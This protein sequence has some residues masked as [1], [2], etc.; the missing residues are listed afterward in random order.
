MY[1]SIERALSNG[2]KFRPL[3]ESIRDTLA[4]FKA[5]RD[6][7]SLRAGIDPERERH[8]LEKWHGQS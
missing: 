1:V 4:W 8:L 7:N 3:A 2:L 6:P 5:G